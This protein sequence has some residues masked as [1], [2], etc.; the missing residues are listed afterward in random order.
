MRRKEAEEEEKEEE[1]EEEEEKEVKEEENK[2][3]V[4]YSHG[5]TSSQA[6]NLTFNLR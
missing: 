2:V 6:G 3:R 4:I 5:Y 1:E